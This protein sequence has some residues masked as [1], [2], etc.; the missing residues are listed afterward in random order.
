MAY[1]VYCEKLNSNGQPDG[2][3]FDVTNGEKSSKYECYSK[4]LGF[5]DN[6]F[7]VFWYL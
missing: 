1:N 4:C 6:T 3:E 2:S 5:K 7:G